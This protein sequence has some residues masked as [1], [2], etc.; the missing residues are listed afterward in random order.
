MKRRHPLHA[1][2]RFCAALQAT[3]NPA[4]VAEFSAW[5]GRPFPAPPRQCATQTDFH[6]QAAKNSED[7]AEFAGWLERRAAFAEE[8]PGPT[9]YKET[10]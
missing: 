4:I 8:C 3:A 10:R 5:R 6:Q 2:F 1:L 7:L 9:N